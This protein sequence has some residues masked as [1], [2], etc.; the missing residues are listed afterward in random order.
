MANNFKEY[1][2]TLIENGFNILPIVP[3]D[4]K[5][6]S[7]PGKAPA[8]KGWQEHTATEEDIT[9]WAHSRAHC[10]IGINTAHTP[11]VDIDVLDKALSDQMAEFVVDLLGP[12]P[13][14]IGR[15][16]KKLLV[17]RTDKPFAKVKSHTWINDDGDRCAV[18]ILGHGQQFVAFGTHPGTGKP[19]TWP[20]GDSPLNHD[21][22]F[23]LNEIDL[24]AARA[25]CDEFDALAKAQGWEKDPKASPTRGHV[26]GKKPEKPVL[27]ADF[28][29][30]DELTEDLRD[31]WDG[32][33][34]ELAGFLEKLPAE[35]EY[36]RWVS[37]LAA[38]KDGEREPDEFKELARA[39]S[40][41][42]PNFDEDAFEDKWENGNFGRLAVSKDTPV[43]KINDIRKW[44]KW[45]EDDKKAL[46]KVVPG[47]N[48][49]ETK[50]TWD[51]WRKRLA[52]LTLSHAVEAQA[53]EAA[54]AAWE[55]VKS[56]G[57]DLSEP[58]NKFG[59]PNLSDRGTPLNTIDNMAY[60]LNEYGI[61][62]RYDEIR[63][64]QR[65][66]GIGKAFSMD[67]RANCELYVVESLCSLNTMSTAS[68]DKF[69]RTLA[70]QNRYNPVEEWVKSKPWD[71]VSRLKDLY[72][73]VE[74]PM[75]LRLKETLIRRWL[76][77]A[78]AMGVDGGNARRQARGVLVF[79]GGQ[80][81]GKTRWALRLG[82]E[83]QN[84]VMEGVA[85]DPDNKDT[86][87]NALTHWVCELGELDATFRRSDIAR[88]KAF[89][90]Q[91]T[92]KV[93]MPYDRRASEYARRTV[94]FASVNE[95][96]FLVDETGNTRWWTI[97]VTA[98]HHDHDIDMQQLWA[99]V[100]ELYR[101]GE[102]WW[103]TA[104]ENKALIEHNRDHESTDPIEE[105]ILEE[106]AW[107]P[108]HY[109][110][111]SDTQ[112]KWEGARMT[113]TEVLKVIG[114]KNPT[115]MLARTA[116]N[117]LRRLAGES[118]KT[119]GGR[120]VFNMPPLAGSAPAG[121]DDSGMHDDDD[122]L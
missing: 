118:R 76:V 71:G 34:E 58:I 14:R 88:M 72:R 92:D 70:D 12:A 19:F 51:V 81:V 117:I 16:P 36:G 93:R 8:L 31:T 3:H 77:S 87:I 69:L 83:D 84:L 7:S 114:Y 27:D 82:P 1:G 59:F 98:V 30:E 74:S 95:H 96:N 116:G 115:K 9:K 48:R 85:V 89:V 22:N 52:K 25:I 50:E 99:E 5:D 67:N 62:C 26:I 42:A 56:S 91:G 23:D 41:K 80:Y 28:D 61:T 78:V 101:G 110:S 37:V 122:E 113:A 121:F 108:N 2:K 102:Q 18:E 55:R 111:A 68:T 107:T 10:G 21:A 53:K 13:L 94:F 45:A 44:V 120:R 105:A 112:E 97:P 90:S 33:V 47:F 6:H 4:A 65:L 46:E 24:P 32:T 38:L 75:N 29:E 39:W 103:L 49:C 119:H 11:A 40:A 64:E 109:K 17:Y 15:A 79:V 104:E 100:Y 43:S 60:L 35:T 57:I 66:T 106:F 73:T 86:V 63:K 54:N 20:N